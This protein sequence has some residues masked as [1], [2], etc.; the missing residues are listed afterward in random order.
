MM[1]HYSPLLKKTCIRQVVLGKWFPLILSAQRSTK[2]ATF[3][4]GAARAAPVWDAPSSARGRPGVCCLLFVVAY[5]C[6]IVLFVSCFVFMIVHS[7]FE[8]QEKVSLNHRD[9]RETS[10]GIRR[11]AGG[12]GEGAPEACLLFLINR[13]V[14]YHLSYMYLCSFNVGVRFAAARGLSGLLSRRLR[15]GVCGTR[16]G[17]TAVGPFNKQT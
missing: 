4:A 5:V 2:P 8:G 12:N 11:G 17:V 15:G 7:L 1:L 3:I 6:G 9:A 16:T 14:S 13:T 10:L